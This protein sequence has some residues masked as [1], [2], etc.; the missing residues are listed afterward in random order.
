MKKER[1]RPE[2]N[3]EENFFT[4]ISRNFK[5]LVFENVD[6]SGRQAGRKISMSESQRAPSNREKG[7][8]ELFSAIHTHSDSWLENYSIKLLYSRNAAF[9]RKKPQGRT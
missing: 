4:F 1:F 9:T 8:L 5:M 3:L 7:K 6:V 2:K